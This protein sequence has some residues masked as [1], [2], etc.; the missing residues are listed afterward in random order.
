MSGARAAEGSRAG[1]CVRA[2]ADPVP[3]G[4]KSPAPAGPR[5]SAPRS[6]RPP[7]LALEASTRPP[8][9][10]L[11]APPRLSS[12]PSCVPIPTPTSAVAPPTSQVT[13]ADEPGRA[14]GGAPRGPLLATHTHRPPGP[15]AQRRGGASRKHPRQA[16]G[17][18]KEA[19]RP[20]PTQL[21]A[22]RWAPGR[23][24][25]LAPHPARTGSAHRAHLPADCAGSPG[26][27][28]RWPSRASGLLEFYCVKAKAR[29]SSRAAWRSSAPFPPTLSLTRPPVKGSEAQMSRAILNVRSCRPSATVTCASS[30]PQAPP[31]V[32]VT[33]GN[34]GE[35]ELS[36]QNTLRPWL[37]MNEFSLSFTTD[38]MS[39]YF[40]TKHYPEYWMIKV[41]RRE[42][43]PW[44]ESELMQVQTLVFIR[45]P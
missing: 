24:S 38:L 35:Q 1:G 25:L 34:P 44:K 36:T 7:P 10:L 27:W 41:K 45:L 2:R 21:A 8:P 19:G 18:K 33:T 43:L 42:T 5:S 4:A 17:E 23:P 16:G 37:R 29:A 14:L 31:L 12:A 20:T 3:P 40:L 11:P 26:R 13:A 9:P 6:Q 30:A 22:L 15:G 39:T 28:G 32:S